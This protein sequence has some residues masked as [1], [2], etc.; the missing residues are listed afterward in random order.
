MRRSAFPAQAAA[1]SSRSEPGSN[2]MTR[3]IVLALALVVAAATLAG[4]R[5]A[6]GATVPVVGPLTTSGTTIRDGN[7]RT[8]VLD[9][10]ARSGLEYGTQT[11]SP[12]A[13]SNGCAAAH[14]QCYP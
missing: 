13:N 2:G 9:G 11:Y 5:P 6:D 4:A 10:I 7:G 12:L 14:V 8:I 1:G 3:R